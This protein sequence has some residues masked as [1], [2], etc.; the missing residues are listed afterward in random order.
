MRL[1]RGSVNSTRAPASS[2]THWDGLSRH[3]NRSVP[4]PHVPTQE[5]NPPI[6]IPVRP[7]PGRFSPPGF[8]PFFGAWFQTRGRHSAGSS[9]AI[10]WSEIGF[11]QFRHC[12]MTTPV[13]RGSA[14]EF[15][16]CQAA[17]HPVK[18]YT[19]AVGDVLQH[20]LKLCSARPGR[21]VL[22]VMPHQASALPRRSSF[23]QD[24]LACFTQCALI[25]HHGLAMPED[26]LRASIELMVAPLVWRSPY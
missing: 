20:S 4:S 8:T 23:T 10:L 1:Q 21:I 6:R 11:L 15:P 12:A 3:R 25:E 5:G 22:R 19:L 13:H 9:V 16:Q 18:M 26:R 17:K 7:D 24:V 14:C 2:I